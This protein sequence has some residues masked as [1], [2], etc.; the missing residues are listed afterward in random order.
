MS[1]AFMALEKD[2]SLQIELLQKPLVSFMDGI[3]G[4]VLICIF[5]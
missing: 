5:I 4:G 2:M 3:L 1:V